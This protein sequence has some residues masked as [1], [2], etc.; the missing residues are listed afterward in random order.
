MSDRWDRAGVFNVVLLRQ[1]RGAPVLDLEEVR[2]WVRQAVIDV[3]LEDAPWPLEAAVAV[4]VPDEEELYEL[5]RSI[6]QLSEHHARVTASEPDR[7]T[8]VLSVPTL[9]VFQTGDAG[10][11]DVREAE[12]YAH[13][14]V[15]GLEPVPGWQAEWR[16]SSVSLERE[17]LDA[18]LATAHPWVA[19]EGFL[20]RF[21]AR[22]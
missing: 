21:G 3:I 18:V 17:W 1:E 15:C 2:R 22:S 5:Y 7:V 6:D 8:T 13:E 10:P 9:V 11:A 20:A 19:S 4:E 16:T 14:A 12:L